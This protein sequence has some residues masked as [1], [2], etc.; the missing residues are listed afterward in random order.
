MGLSFRTE[1]LEHE[2]FP[3]TCCLDC[4]AVIMAAVRIGA[5]GI[6][7]L[8]N[9]MTVNVILFGT[10]AI[11]IVVAITGG[12]IEIKEIK[13]PRLPR[14]SRIGAALGGIIF[15][16]LGIWVHLGELP[17]RDESLSGHWIGTTSDNE[18]TVQISL[19]RNKD[20][21]NYLCSISAGEAEAEAE[22]ECTIAVRGTNVSIFSKVKNTDSS[23][24]W[25]PDD[26]ELQFQNGQLSGRLIS[27]RKAYDIIFRRM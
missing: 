11:L 23:T 20:G 12:G 22:E 15:I 5:L 1:R 26:F 18:T 25:D 17:F 16:A 21:E 3:E 6:K 7:S 14:L 8:E 2:S 4:G 9:V 10:G 19:T 24:G 27:K 13:L